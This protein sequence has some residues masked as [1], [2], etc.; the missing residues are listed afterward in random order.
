MKL[1]REMAVQAL[2][3]QRRALLAPVAV[4]HGK[5]VQRAALLAPLAPEQP[6][7]HGDAV[8][9]RRAPPLDAHRAVRRGV[10]L[11]RGRARG[12]FLL[13]PPPLAPEQPELHG[14]A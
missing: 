12:R 2:R 14:D 4:I 10:A 13:G 1:L 8:L 11:R 9:H 6:E 5:E 3:A 7:L